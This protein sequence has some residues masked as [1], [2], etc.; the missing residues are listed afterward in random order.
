MLVTAIHA[1]YQYS[2]TEKNKWIPKQPKKLF[3]LRSINK[4]ADNMTIIWNKHAWFN[5][6]ELWARMHLRSNE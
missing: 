4:Y 3:V 5:S 2:K 6:K 1:K